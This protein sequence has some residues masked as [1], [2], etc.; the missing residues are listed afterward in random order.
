MATA[1]P[2]DSNPVNPA[3]T[4]VARGDFAVPLAW[5]RGI[6]WMRRISWLPQFSWLRR[7]PALAAQLRGFGM[8]AVICT[9]IS[10][11]IFAALRP[12]MGTQWANSISL[13]LCS[14]LNTDL[15]RR[16]SFGLRTRHLW[17]R[18][19][20]RG[21]GV[22]LM[23]LVM[24]TGSLWILHRVSPGAS[25][26]VELMVIV[27]GNVASAVTRFVLLRYWVFRR[28]RHGAAA[29]GDDAPRDDAPAL[30]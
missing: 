26:V 11:T 13:V 3:P 8:V 25:I 12:T 5:L 28:V 17:W 1:A 30:R 2:P 23:A 18:D 22:M 14:V 29:S 24:T 19:Q 7:K 27:L 4:D 20:R 21:L 6:A 10:M 15:N 16:M 9:V